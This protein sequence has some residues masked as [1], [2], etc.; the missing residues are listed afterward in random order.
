MDDVE[1]TKLMFEMMHRHK[2]ALQQ[3]F[4]QAQTKGEIRSD[5]PVNTLFRLVFG[6]VRLL[7]KQWGMTRCG[8]DLHT[9]CEELLSSLRLVLK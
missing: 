1:F 3:Y 7:I 6:P 8:F 4:I 9:E 2:A 5:I